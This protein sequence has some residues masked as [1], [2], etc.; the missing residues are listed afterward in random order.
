[1]NVPAVT[2]LTSEMSTQVLARR[3]DTTPPTTVPSTDFNLTQEAVKQI[4]AMQ[5]SDKG[6]QV[7]IKV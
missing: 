6:G 2:Q 7:D 1:M 4:A 3:G 5:K